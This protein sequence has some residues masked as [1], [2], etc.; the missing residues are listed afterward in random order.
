VGEDGGFSF[1]KWSV[2]DIVI[3]TGHRCLLSVGDTKDD[4]SGFFW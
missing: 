1:D 3:L 2:L 4:S